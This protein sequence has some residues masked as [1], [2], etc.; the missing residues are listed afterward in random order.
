MLEYENPF[1]INCKPGVDSL[2]VC[3]RII[4]NIADA[5]IKVNQVA[6]IAKRKR[7]EKKEGYWIIRCR[8]QRL[9]QH[10]KRTRRT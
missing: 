10:R 9:Y 6:V 7:K 4:V 2:E 3:S 5:Q 8:N 1:F